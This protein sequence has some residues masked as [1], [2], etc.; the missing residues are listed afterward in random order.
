MFVPKTVG[1]AKRY[2][3]SAVKQHINGWRWRASQFPCCRKQVRF[4]AV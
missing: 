2:S 1:S 4:C 3:R